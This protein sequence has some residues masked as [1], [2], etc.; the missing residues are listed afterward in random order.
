MSPTSKFCPQHPKIV[1][2]LSNHLK[3]LIGPSFLIFFGP[4][5]IGFGPWIHVLTSNLDQK[6]PPFESGPKLFFPKFLVEIDDHVQKC[7]FGQFSNSSNVNF[8]S[9]F[10]VRLWTQSVLVM[11]IQYVTMNSL[12]HFSGPKLGSR[13]ELLISM[14]HRVRDILNRFKIS[15]S[16][17]LS[18]RMSR[19]GTFGLWLDLAF[20]RTSRNIKPIW[21]W[22]ISIEERVFGIFDPTNTFKLLTD[23]W[24][25]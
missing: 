15:R 6:F 11:H 24:K 21:F 8:G 16:E 9:R 23:T 4:G 22:R 25:R 13:V 1:T 2:I 14:D 20:K 10:E 17:E 12:K 19:R 7:S 18:D 3:V 5:K